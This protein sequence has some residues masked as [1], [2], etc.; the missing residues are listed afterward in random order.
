MSA[1]RASEADRERWLEL[2][3]ALRPDLGLERHD[4]AIGR[5]LGGGGRRA[6]F[7]FQRG[8]ALASGFVE[9]TRDS[10]DGGIGRVEAIYVVPAARRQGQARALL[11]AASGWATRAGCRE[12][13]CSWPIDDPA[14][15]ASL[16]A[17]GFAETGREVLFSRTLHPAMALDGARTST[18]RATPAAPLPALAAVER[19]A[20]PRR[21]VHGSIICAGIV[22]L[23]MTDIFSGDLL[24]GAL[25]PLLDLLFMLYLLAM[26][27]GHQYQR[28]TDSSERSIRLFD[29]APPRADR[30]G[31]E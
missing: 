4:A 7:V 21:L 24:R 6:A 1:R 13:R 15:H 29:A 18:T 31:A 8:V 23:L 12:L 5:V 19:P 25:L 27:A 28:R 3:A 20:G 2:R 26:I 14:A 30:D 16:A 9:V 22:S 17:L 11:D 10:D